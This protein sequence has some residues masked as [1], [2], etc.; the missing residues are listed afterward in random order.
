MAS[1]Y[2][3]NS[4]SRFQAFYNDH[5]KQR[6]ISSLLQME[7]EKLKLNQ[8][9]KQ[10]SY[11]VEE[12]MLC[13]ICKAV[14]VEPMTLSCGHTFCRFCLSEEYSSQ[15]CSICEKQ[16]SLAENTSPT[17]LLC[18]VSAKWF[19]KEV[20]L[21]KIKC[22]AQ[23]LLRQHDFK[24]ALEH[25]CS[26]AVLEGQFKLDPNYYCLKA[27]CNA[28]LGNQNLALEN[29]ELAI[30]LSPSAVHILRRKAQIL[31]EM[32]DFEKAVLVNVRL[33]A[34]EPSNVKMK[35]EL[36]SSLN[37]LLHVDFTNQKDGTMNQGHPSTETNTANVVNS[38]ARLNDRDISVLFTENIQIDAEQPNRGTKE[39]SH[40][41]LSNEQIFTDE[42]DCKLCCSLLYKP[43]TTPCGHTFCDECLRR[44]LD[45]RV[46]CPCCRR[47]LTNY[48]AE[49]RANVTLVIENIIKALFPREYQSRKE[50]IEK[51]MKAMKV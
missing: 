2:Q 50:A 7:R 34:L 4:Q 25:L 45:F 30:G 31:A 14:F 46:D 44:S 13:P 37:G 20:Q 38:P 43:V 33:V 28:G 24:S 6:L 29:I 49:R 12:F 22:T 5:S 48:L 21:A 19:P 36:E 35:G 27:E 16:E 51:E 32:G 17:F 41:T 26:K 1:T 9:G 40:F 18:N 8:V 3:E 47:P 10:R 23:S 15:I 39:Q 11:T 42:F